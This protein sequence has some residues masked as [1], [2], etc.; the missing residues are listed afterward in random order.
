MQN[1]FERLSTLSERPTV[2]SRMR[3]LTPAQASIEL[4]ERNK[5][6]TDIERLPTILDVEDYFRS[7]HRSIRPEHLTKPWITEAPLLD[8]LIQA[9]QEHD[10]SRIN[11]I[12][13]LA[14]AGSWMS[15]ERQT[16]EM[17]RARIRKLRH[18]Q[19]ASWGREIRT[20][21]PSTAEELKENRQD[22]F[23]ELDTI[24]EALSSTTSPEVIEQA[25]QL[26]ERIQTEQWKTLRM[27]MHT[28]GFTDIEQAKKHPLLK[29]LVEELDLI[30][31]LRDELVFRLRWPNWK[32]QHPNEP[33]AV[34]SNPK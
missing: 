33:T 20:A 22:F 17:L 4:R 18:T 26:M 29:N 5:K 23:T 15:Y 27:G 11:L 34:D 16:S 13:G 31:P 32:K 30:R 6:D 8:D 14:R 12:R 21:D 3:P 7:T 10:D 19:E 1:P 28:R 2:F 9:K 25:L 24:D